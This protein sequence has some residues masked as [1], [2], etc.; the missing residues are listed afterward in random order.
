MEEV[1]AGGRPDR[2]PEERPA[3]HAFVLAPAD[4]DRIRTAAREGLARAFRRLTDERVLPRSQ[5]R[6]WIR[7]GRDYFGPALE[8]SEGPLNQALA[9]AL[10]NRFEWRTREAMDLTWN[11]PEA[12]VRAAV[13]AATEADEP[14]DVTSPSVMTAIDSLIESIQRLPGSTVL[15]VIADLDVE[16]ATVPPGHQDRLGESIEIDGVR[17]IRVSNSPER[18]IERELPSAGFEVDRM[19]VVV[20]PPPESLVVATV[21]GLIPDE[22]RVREARAR[23][24]RVVAALRLA[25][26]A[27]IQAVVEI[28]GQSGRLHGHTPYITRLPGRADLRFVHRA[29]TVSL[30]DLHGLEGLS[31]CVGSFEGKDEWLAIRIALGRLSRVLDGSSPWFADQVVDIAVGMEAALAG[32]DVDEISLRLRTRAATIL[33]TVDDPPDGIY[34]DVKTLYAIRSKI[35]HGSTLLEAQLTKAVNSVTGTD[36]TPMVGDRYLLALDRWRDLLR[37]AILARIALASASSHSWPASRKVPEKLD[38]DE[39]LLRPMDREAWRDHIRE[40]WIQQG[41]SAAFGRP[42]PSSFLGSD[43]TEKQLTT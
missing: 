23:I 38:V 5:N 18:F 1:H 28:S 21:Q 11:Y 41:L 16:H 7:V 4:E 6:P 24:D 37:R 35:V 27:T 2:N 8:G 19:D 40:F 36:V 26:G 20:F 12:L 31:K 32:A 9:S 42:R 34:R 25:T 3:S 22:E 33:S 39:I 13:A 30:A 43:R 29:T 10:P 14:Y 17:V 15:R